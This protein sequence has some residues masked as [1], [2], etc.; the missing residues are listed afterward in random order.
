M[1]HLGQFQIPCHFFIHYESWVTLHLYGVGYSEFRLPSSPPIRMQEKLLP[2][3]LVTSLKR[4]FSVSLSSPFY[5][6]FYLYL[7]FNIRTN[8]TFKH[9]SSTYYHS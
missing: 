8:T 7:N 9:V 6:C 5:H 1:I 3:P 4:I 2:W